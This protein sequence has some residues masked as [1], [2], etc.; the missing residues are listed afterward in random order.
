MQVTVS[1][2]DVHGSA[3]APPSKSYTHRAVL[4]AGYTAGT[5]RV[6]N[7]LWSADTRET[8]G[9]V[10]AF[11]GDTVDVD[12]TAEIDGFD[13]RPGV[14]EDILDCGNSGTTMRLVTAAAGLVDGATVLTGDASLRSRPQG[15][16]LDALEQLGARAISTRGN[17]QAP[18]VVEGP[19]AGGDVALPGD[20]SSQFVTALLM[21]GA[22]TDRGI[23]IELTTELKSA[24][25]V[26]ITL[27]VLDSFGVDA[28]ETDEGYRVP[29][30]QS[31]APDDGEY[32]VPGDFSS[33]SYLLAAGALAGDPSVDVRGLYPSVQGDRAI[34]DVLKEMGAS[35]D[36]NTE[37]GVATVERS[38]LSGVTADV[39]DTPD[40]LPTIAVLGAAADGT[41]RIENAEHVRY[42]ET[43]RVAAMASEL[44]KMGAD[45]EE[46][47]DAL[48]VHGDGSNLEGA[49]LDGHGD[50]RIVMALA[51]AALVADGD[52]T[53]SHAEHV[54]V[55]FPQF[56]DELYD[57]GVSVAH[58]NE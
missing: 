58:E 56:F 27:D 19:I 47:P 55:S 51:T 17:G 42:K 11:G 10:S 39:G 24:P 21:A 8:M 6:K 20:V 34:L 36:W 40:L 18:L 41:T 7:A 22:V 48:V 15:A 45:V 12:G 28:S 43:D 4:A 32:D 14:P 26:D 25:Y 49:V 46:E 50:H 53:I 31:Y 9:A 57:L 35:V 33:A 52:S 13:G 23:D 29:G 1:P 37:D 38:A 2:S 30:G 54:E 16:L 44:A 5:T 3:Y